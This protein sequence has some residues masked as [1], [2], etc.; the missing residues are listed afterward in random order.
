MYIY[1]YIDMYILKLAGEKV[2]IRCS[3]VVDFALEGGRR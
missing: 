2:T 1:L 3:I